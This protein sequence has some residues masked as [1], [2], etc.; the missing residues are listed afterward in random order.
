MNPNQNSSPIKY[1]L[2]IEMFYL[3]TFLLLLFSF[4]EKRKNEQKKN[5]L[6]L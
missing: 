6:H 3:V 4:V 1:P 2:N 5:N